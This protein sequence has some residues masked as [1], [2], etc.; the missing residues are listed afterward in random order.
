MALQ[1]LWRYAVASDPRMMAADP[2]SA[3]GYGVESLRI[4]LFFFFFLRWGYL[5]DG[6]V[7]VLVLFCW[8]QCSHFVQLCFSELS[9]QA[10]FSDLW[11]LNCNSMNIFCEYLSLVH[12]IIQSHFS[13]CP[14]CHS[15]S[16]SLKPPTVQLNIRP[17]TLL[18][19]DQHNQ[20]GVLFLL[21][22]VFARKKFA[23]GSAA[24]RPSQGR[25]FIIF[26]T[27][28]NGW[29]LKTYWILMENVWSD[30]I[31]FFFPL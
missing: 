1:G 29:T 28:K 16:I 10:L 23:N 7:G 9:S 15:C 11:L 19:P 27:D 6:S 2:L 25:L 12:F 13:S 3:V 14:I 5:E 4:G 18:S 22:C 26:F 31:F 20:T 8:A 30:V 24:P 21:K 17:V